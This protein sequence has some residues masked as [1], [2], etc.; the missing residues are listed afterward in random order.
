MTDL[1]YSFRFIVYASLELLMLTLPFL[2]KGQSL[3]YRNISVR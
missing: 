1:V 3:F 2:R